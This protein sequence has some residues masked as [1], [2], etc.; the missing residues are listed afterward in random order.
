MRVE[1]AGQSKRD[2]LGRLLCNVYV[3]E[4]DVAAEMIRREHAVPY[5][6]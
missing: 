6:R 1:F 5:R 3:G 4:I 2:S